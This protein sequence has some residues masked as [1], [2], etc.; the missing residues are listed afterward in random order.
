MKDIYWAE[1]AIETLLKKNKTLAHTEELMDAL[2]NHE[3]QTHK[4]VLRLEKIFQ[5]NENG[6][7]GQKVRSCSRHHQGSRR[8][9][10]KNS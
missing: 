8:D 3:L 5:K 1:K 2:E 4:H 10:R 7:G 6:T 9:D